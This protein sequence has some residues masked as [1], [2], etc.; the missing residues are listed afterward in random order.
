MKTKNNIATL[1][2]CSVLAFLTLSTARA[3]ENWKSVDLSHV[4][5]PSGMVRDVLVD[6]LTD[7]ECLALNIYHEAWGEG[8]KGMALIAQVT[9]VRIDSVCYKNTACGAVRAPAQFSWTEDGQWD[10]AYNQDFYEK[11]YL[12]AIQFLFLDR[13]A[14]IEDYLDEAIFEY[15]GFTEMNLLTN[16]HATWVNPV[17]KDTTIVF[18]FRGHVFRVL[19]GDASVRCYA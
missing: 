4:E 17:W 18:T 16:F 9:V 5:V 15:T 14:E 11:S 19:I 10:F 1:F 3:G 2:V 12:M 7:V 6:D 13:R 8:E